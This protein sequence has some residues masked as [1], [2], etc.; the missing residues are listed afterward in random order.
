MRVTQNMLDRNLMFALAKNLERLGKLN[1]QLSTGQR[2]NTVSDDVVDA[3]Q[4][5]RLQRENDRISSYLSNLDSSDTMLSFATSML[6]RT[7]E[8]VAGIKELAIQAA[9]ET[10][11]A[12]DRQ[13]MA[14][15]VDSLLD[16]L[17]GLANSASKGAYL[18]SG[19]ATDTA[20]Y[21]VQ[22]DLSG[23]V[24]AVTYEGEMI[25]TQVSV[26][27]RATTEVNLVGESV[28]RRT[29]DLFGTVIALRDAIAASDRDEIN[30][31]IGELDTS[32]TDVRQSLGRLGERQTQLQATR[33]SLEMIKGLNTQAATDKQGADVA[34]VAVEYNSMMALLQMVMKVAA[35]AVTPSLIDYI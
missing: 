9:T 6:Q 5:M 18:F 21:A 14:A 23:Q 20:P 26:G 8:T 33:T 2:I 30:R 3:G 15:G 22:A 7:S 12:T 31:L 32:H 17:I 1:E 19:E 4:V 13:V 16:T 24:Q 10:Y 35:E 27:P 34:Q 25:S 28:F 11:T 29:G